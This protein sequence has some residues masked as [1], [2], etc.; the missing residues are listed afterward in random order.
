MQPG[1]RPH[2]LGSAWESEGFRQLGWRL[3][4]LRLFLGITFLYASLQKL[5]NPNYL[6]PSSPTSAA[7]QMKALESSSPIGPLLR[8][9]LHAPTLVA[10]LI[11][12]GELA[13]AL[14]ILA[15][16][17]TRLAAIGGMLLSLSFFLTVSWATTPY[18]YGSDI[19][20]AFAWSVFITCGAGGV[21]SLDAW[22]EARTPSGTSW[23]DR[24]VDHARRR[25]LVGA[26]STALLAAIAGILGGATAVIGRAAGGTRSGGTQALTQDPLTPSSA[27][28]GHRSRPTRPGHDRSAPPTRSSSRPAT[29]S[30]S[31]APS[32]TALAPASAVPVGHGRQFTDP[33]S[34][35]PAWL[36]RR[37][38]STVAAFSAVCT[39]AGCTVG[40][41]ASSDEFICPCHGGR[42]SARTGAV[43]GGPPPSPLSQIPAR[44]VNHEIRVD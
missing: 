10:L 15:G 1:V 43:L 6:R 14:G 26:R 19:V 33:A 11:A 8:L 2:P 34:G 31:H 13:V 4:P 40:Y 37:S 12:I 20:F 41:D 9:S 32:G 36:L 7:A 5:A 18:F 25:L 3:L 29:H 42:Y 16:L 17:W 23:S 22:I 24:P 44:I 21:L 28:A 39:H 35:Q 30:R 38:A 27:P